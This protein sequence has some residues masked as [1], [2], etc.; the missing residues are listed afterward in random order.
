MAAVLLVFATVAAFSGDVQSLDDI[1][2]GHELGSSASNSTNVTAVQEMKEP[3][4]KKPST[5]E[6]AEL[7]S[8]KQKVR[9]IEQQ[10]GSD[11]TD[12]EV[13]VLAQRLMQLDKANK[14]SPREREIEE[15][16]RRDGPPETHVEVDPEAWE[17]QTQEREKQAEA[18]RKERERQLE[19][20]QE[21]AEA[22]ANEAEHVKDM[23]E[24]YTEETMDPALEKK[25][26][27]AT[28]EFNKASQREKKLKPDP[29]GPDP[30]GVHDKAS[31]SGADKTAQSKSAEAEEAASSP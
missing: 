7:E 27:A 8:Y 2:V 14:K 22:R 24:R 15:A 23:L 21:M 4:E 17:A 10:R 19:H 3:E 12:G 6:E 31:W 26:Q 13:T 28:N 29:D 25:I 9:E 20:Q 11:P 1:T 30:Y 18:K 5:A 16:L